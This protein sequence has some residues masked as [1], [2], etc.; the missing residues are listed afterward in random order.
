MKSFNATNL[1]RKSGIRGPKTMGAALRSGPRALGSIPATAKRWKH[2]SPLPPRTTAD[3]MK[4]N[5]FMRTREF[6]G[7]P[8]RYLPL[9]K[10][11]T[12]SCGIGNGAG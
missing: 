2:K 1:D 12:Q 4:A 11:R 5:L 9:S 7:S 6:C 8:Q 3:I 10:T